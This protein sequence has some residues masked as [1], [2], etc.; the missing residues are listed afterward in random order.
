MDL[1]Y[2]VEIAE[3]EATRFFVGD[4][5][6]MASLW[7]VNAKYINRRGTI[8]KLTT[9]RCN[10]ACP[11]HEMIDIKFDEGG[12]NRWGGGSDFYCSSAY[13]RLTDDIENFGWKGE[14][15]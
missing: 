9:E 12:T 10:A 14:I 3:P 6:A 1:L 7:G 5:V 15:E 11:G 4:R 2:V 8:I 13:V